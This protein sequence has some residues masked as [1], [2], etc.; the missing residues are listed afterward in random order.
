MENKEKIKLLTEEECE[1]LDLYEL[2]L[3]LEKLNKLCEKE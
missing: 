2:C 3:Y 1:K